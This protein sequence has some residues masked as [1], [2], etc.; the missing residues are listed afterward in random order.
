LQLDF[1]EPFAKAPKESFFNPFFSNLAG[2]EK[3]QVQIEKA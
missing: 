2:T 3:L 1:S